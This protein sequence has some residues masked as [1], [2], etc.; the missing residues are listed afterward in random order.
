MLL[1]VNT[2]TALKSN[3]SLNVQNVVAACMIL[4]HGTAFCC[5][6]IFV[7]Q[8][9]SFMGLGVSA[10]AYDREFYHAYCQYSSS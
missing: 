3:I 10:N 1:V 6:T 7:R 8:G 4:L 9:A 2:I 5:P